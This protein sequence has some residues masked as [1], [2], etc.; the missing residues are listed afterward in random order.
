MVR[1]SFKLLILNV[2][3][4]LV[5]SRKAKQSAPVPVP[6]LNIAFLNQ[7]STIPCSNSYFTAMYV[8]S[9]PEDSILKDEAALKANS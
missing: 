9:I 8:D 2:R 1:T 7:L 6:L 3:N 5:K 4:G